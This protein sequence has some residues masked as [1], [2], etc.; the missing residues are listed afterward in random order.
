VLS[1]QPSQDQIKI[2]TKE[3]SKAKPKE[4]TAGQFRRELNALSNQID[5]MTKQ[6]IY[7]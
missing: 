6:T 4:T 3:K 7:H 5:Q 2:K 1:L